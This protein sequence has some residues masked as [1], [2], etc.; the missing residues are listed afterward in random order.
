MVPDQIATL[1]TRVFPEN[2]DGVKDQLMKLND[3]TGTANGKL[4]I[5]ESF[6]KA[7]IEAKRAGRA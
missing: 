2:I 3:E 6:I 5:L 1:P 7:Y 4:S